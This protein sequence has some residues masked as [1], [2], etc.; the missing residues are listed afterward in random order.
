[1]QEFFFWFDKIAT[2][3]K[4]WW[5]DQQENK[6]I[7]SATN[8]TAKKKK[9]IN[10]FQTINPYNNK[11]K[12]LNFSVTSKTLLNKD[13]IAALEDA[14]KNF[15]KEEADTIRAKISLTFQNSKPP[16]NKLSKDELQAFRGLQFD[17]PIVRFW[18]HLFLRTRLDCCF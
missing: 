10:V 15:E 18:E 14:V 8:I 16:K 3:T 1:M 9:V 2:Y 17:T 6:V 5:T 7:Q 13:I 4:I 12:G 11:V